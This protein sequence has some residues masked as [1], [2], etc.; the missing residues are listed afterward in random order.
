MR[1]AFYRV[2]EAR[3]P[4][5][6]EGGTGIPVSNSCR[7]EDHLAISKLV[8]NSGNMVH[9][10]A[11][12][13]LLDFDRANS[14]QIHIMGLLANLKSAKK[15]GELINKNFDVLVLTFS[16]II[17]KGPSETGLLQVLEHLTIPIYAFGIGLQDSLKLSSIDGIDS[18]L[19]KLLSFLNNSAVIFGVRGNQTKKYLDSINLN[20][21]IALGCPSMFAYS[22]NVLKISPPTSHERIITAGHFQLTADTSRRIHRLIKGFNGY[23]PAYVF[24][25]ELKY[26]KELYMSDIFDEATQSIDFSTIN[27]YVEKK[28]KIKSPFSKYYSFTETSAW[29][30]AYLQYDLFIGDRIHGGVVAMQVGKPAVVLH[31]DARVRELTA[32]HGIPSCSLK[33]F[34]EQGFEQVIRTELS[35]QRI[36]EFKNRYVS[37]LNKFVKTLT[38]NG[39]KCHINTS[40]K[41]QE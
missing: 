8:G 9:R 1:I 30:Q 32:Y 41:S 17:R 11:M 24:Q 4:C 6:V 23:R 22:W 38:K 16:N 20:N 39:L 29:R 40:D 36:E 37:V 5:T 25:G 2:A 15:V 27:S 35:S 14:T 12:L 10:M 19:L 3:F 33:A 7:L 31:E 28:L 13:Q 21:S 18:E 34:E 26:F